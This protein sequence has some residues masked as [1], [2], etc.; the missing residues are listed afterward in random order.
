VFAEVASVFPGAFVHSGGDEPFGMP[1]DRHRSFVRHVRNTLR[2]LGKRPVEWQE[3][4][5]AGA[6]FADLIQYWISSTGPPPAAQENIAASDRD[7][8]RAMAHGVRVIMSPIQHAYFD[9]PYAEESLDRTQE[10]VR[11]RLGLRS[12]SPRS[13]DETYDWE[14]LEALG[15]GA[16]PEHLAGVGGAVWTETVRDF[17]DLMFLLLPRLAGTADK[18]WSAPEHA[19]WAEH[20]QRLATQYRLW[21]QDGLA[22]F[23][24]CR[25][26]WPPD[27]A[28]RS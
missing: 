27:T 28:V 2:S 17:S 5:R 11:Q 18:A 10:S 13:I 16:G 1:M 20:R 14:P 6:E 7:V 23:R 12:Y 9:V 24:S 22:Y 8:A 26:D 25:V 15:Q 3:S 4:M 19:T 21:T